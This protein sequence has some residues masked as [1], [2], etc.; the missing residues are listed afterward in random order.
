M[1]KSDKK[2]DNQLRLALTDVCQH[3]IE[4]YAGFEWITHTVDYGAFPKSLRIVCVFD[5][6]QQ[7]RQFNHQGHKTALLA[8]IK[9]CLAD[10]GIEIN[11]LDK[12]VSFDSETAC[13]QQHNGNWALRLKAANINKLH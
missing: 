8:H 2:I 12:Q 7:L 6:E 9:R 1:R 11:N 13:Q 4:L 5:T 10:G 3:A